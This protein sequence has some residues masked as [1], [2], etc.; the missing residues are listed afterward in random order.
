MYKPRDRAAVGLLRR[1]HVH[2]SCSVYLGK[3]ANKLESVRG[4]LEHNLSDVLSV[5]F[6]PSQDEWAIVLKP[7]LAAVRNAALATA[8]GVS[9]RAARAWRNG[10]TRPSRFHVD[11]LR[12]FLRTQAEHDQRSTPT[13]RKRSKRKKRRR[14]ART[15]KSVRTLARPP[16]GGAG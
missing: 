2:A 4:G 8:L 13:R 7:Q 9:E 3:E 14:P 5:Y 16:Y 15:L 12:E 1:R 11:A 6:D 10:Q